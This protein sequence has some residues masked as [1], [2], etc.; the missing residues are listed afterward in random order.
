MNNL[1]NSKRHVLACFC[2]VLACFCDVDFCLF[3]LRLWRGVDNGEHVETSALS[4]D[5]QAFI[6]IEALKPMV[7]KHVGRICFNC[8]KKGKPLF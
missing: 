2:D 3:T 6:Q 7:L 4:M 8:L 1:S 5:E